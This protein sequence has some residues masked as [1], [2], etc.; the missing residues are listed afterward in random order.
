[1]IMKIKLTG[2]G[3]QGIQF[4]G[5]ILAEAAFRQRLNV[6]QA[7]MYEPSTQGGLTVA[8]IIIAPANDEIIYPYI[9]RDPNILLVLAQRAWDEYMDIV[10]PATII[11]FD[12]TNVQN[13]MF[14]RKCNM[15]LKVPFSETARSLGS[16]NVTN[17]V[18]LGF[19]SEMLDIGGHFVPEILKEV[20]PED[21]L[22]PSL[23]EVS[24]QQFMESIIHMSPRRFRE[25]NLKAFKL[26]Y[27]MSMSMD[28]EDAK[29]KCS[30][31]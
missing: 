29:I 1:M 4:L 31:I 10:G 23:L 11:L 25:I 5:K 3:G 15:A 16:E 18:A 8:D 24:P 17:I 9:D 19:L 7:V 30:Q 28:Y 21:F 26:G 27:S 12:Q 13:I 14:T 6:S 2:V 22:N 20:E